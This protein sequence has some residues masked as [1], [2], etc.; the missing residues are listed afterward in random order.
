LGHKANQG[1]KSTTQNIFITAVPSSWAYEKN[2]ETARANS[3]RKRSKKERKKMY[4]KAKS[5]E[6]IEEMA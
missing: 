2:V 6:H 1:G 5:A 4:I 3:E